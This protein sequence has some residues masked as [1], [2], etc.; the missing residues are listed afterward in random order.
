[1]SVSPDMIQNCDAMSRTLLDNASQEDSGKAIERMKPI[2]L[3][4]IFVPTRKEA[5]DNAVADC[6]LAVGDLRSGASQL[7]DDSVEDA[8]QQ[9]LIDNGSQIA[10]SNLAGSISS[11]ASDQSEEG[12]KLWNMIKAL[13]VQ[14]STNSPKQSTVIRETLPGSFVSAAVLLQGMN[15]SERGTQG[16]GLDTN[17]AS[18]KE[19]GGTTTA[20]IGPETYEGTLRVKRDDW[21]QSP[22]CIGSFRKS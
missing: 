21:G 7:G 2:S 16:T 10:A 6:N 12:I 18:E 11:L 19:K 14:R 13:V 8:V 4:S 9:G 22:G 3:F 15:E 1:M 20:S 17:V 5:K